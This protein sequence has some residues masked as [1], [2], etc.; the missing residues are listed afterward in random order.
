[1]GNASSKTF[2][3]VQS[4]RMVRYAVSARIASMTVEEENRWLRTEEQADPALMKLI[5]RA[6]DDTRRDDKS[7]GKSDGT[8]PAKPDQT[9][10]I[11]TKP[12]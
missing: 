8:I 10:P 12:D 9:S 7:V 6:T 4:V 2:D 11:L 5:G 3:A 1:V